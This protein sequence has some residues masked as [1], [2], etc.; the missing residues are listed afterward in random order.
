MRQK[1]KE[2]L[3][4]YSKAPTASATLA[5]SRRPSSATLCRPWAT[6]ALRPARAIRVPSSD[7]P[8]ASSPCSPRCNGRGSRRKSPGRRLRWKWNKKSWVGTM[9]YL[10]RT[11]TVYINVLPLIQDSLRY[12]PRPTFTN[13]SRSP[14]Q[15]VLY[16]KKRFTFQGSI[17][18]TLIKI[19]DHKCKEVLTGASGL[20]TLCFR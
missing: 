1:T 9:R 16:F 11:E 2:R 8:I 4:S 14:K 10:S 17:A 5:D 19:R 13:E 7:A 15:G 12:I 3:R 6:A 18:R 20:L